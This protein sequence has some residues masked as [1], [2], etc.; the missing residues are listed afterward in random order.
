[1]A[2]VPKTKAEQLLER[3]GAVWERPNEIALYGILR[4]ARAMIARDGESALLAHIAA[5]ALERRGDLGGASAY[6]RDCVRLDPENPGAHIN[7]GVVLLKLGDN[8][9]GRDSLMRAADLSGEAGLKNLVLLANLA[10][11]LWVCDDRASAVLCLRMAETLAEPGNRGHL[12][13]LADA[14]AALENHL[15]AVALLAECL[16]AGEAVPLQF[17]LPEMGWLG[18]RLDESVALTDAQHRSLEFAEGVAAASAA[19]RELPSTELDA[20]RAELLAETA[21]MRGRANAA[22]VSQS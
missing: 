11:A 15:R 17:G 10:E 18:E 12:W 14:H 13:R 6:R 1:M 7:L 9:A 2:G 19:A 4:D 21:W 3:L 8:K 16:A 5:A 22:A 20:H